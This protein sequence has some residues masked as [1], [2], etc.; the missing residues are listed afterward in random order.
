MI[1]PDT[2]GSVTTPEREA[3]VRAIYA[4]Q[5][6]ERAAWE[7]TFAGR[8]AKFTAPWKRAWHA[9]HDEDSGL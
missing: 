1:D 5:A 7:K 3:E 2:L 4:R 6:A 9:F 8:W